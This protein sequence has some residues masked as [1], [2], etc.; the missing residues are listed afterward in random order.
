M[1]L[2]PRWNSP[3]I[4]FG[5]GLLYTAIPGGNAPPVLAPIGNKSINEG[6]PLSEQDLPVLL[7]YLARTFKPER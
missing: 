1:T 7:R 4:T 6:A 2:N 3:D 5:A